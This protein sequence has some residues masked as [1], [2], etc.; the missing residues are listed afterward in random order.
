MLKC[1]ITKYLIFL[2]EFAFSKFLTNA[3]V[4]QRF[5]DDK[6]VEEN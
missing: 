3:K 5:V 4:H 6:K 2:Q 1:L